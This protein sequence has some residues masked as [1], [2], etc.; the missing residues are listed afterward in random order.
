MVRHVHEG[1]R[2]FQSTNELEMT[3]ADAWSNISLEL[4]KILV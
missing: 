3:T 1:G 4:C 2:Q